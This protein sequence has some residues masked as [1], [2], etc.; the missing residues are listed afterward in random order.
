MKIFS[1]IVT[2]NMVDD[3]FDCGL[4]LPNKFAIEGQYKLFP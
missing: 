3:Q 1:K 2:N 4:G